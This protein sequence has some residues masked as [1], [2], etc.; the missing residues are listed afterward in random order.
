MKVV[1]SRKDAKSANKR[2]KKLSLAERAGRTEEIFLFQCF[3]R[4]LRN[5]RI[6]HGNVIYLKLG[7]SPASKE[8]R[9]KERN[10]E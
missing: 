1:D 2:I 10:P 4:N 6:G 9:R 5:L 3:L 8:L 7:S